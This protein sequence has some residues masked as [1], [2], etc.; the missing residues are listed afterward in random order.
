MLRN[1]S[2]YIKELSIKAYIFDLFD[3]KIYLFIRTDFKSIFSDFFDKLNNFEDWDSS[4]DV[5][6]KELIKIK[7]D[8]KDPNQ[9]DKLFLIEK[10]SPRYFSQEL[11]EFPK[12]KNFYFVEKRNKTIENILKN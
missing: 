4:Y 12:I 11:Y 7:L 3:K 6:L 1:N 9:I 10:N 2:T 5:L 8:I